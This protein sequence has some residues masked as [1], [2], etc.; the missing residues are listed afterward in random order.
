[1]RAEGV[2]AILS[3]AIANRRGSEAQMDRETVLEQFSLFALGTDGIGGWLGPGTDVR[4]LDRLASIDSEPLAKVQLNQLFAF[5]HE[6]PVSDEFFSYYWL[7]NPPNHPYDVARLA[8]FDAR[9][10]TSSAIISIPHLR[11]GLRRLYNDGLL[12]FGKC[13]NCL[14]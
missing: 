9:W 5:G 7:S 14:P 12:Y 6:A 4:V 3:Q 8:D 10:L 1:V 11:W 2:T 13:E